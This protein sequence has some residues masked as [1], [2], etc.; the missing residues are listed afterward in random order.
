MDEDGDEEEDKV[1]VL[2]SDLGLIESHFCKLN[3][4]KMKNQIIN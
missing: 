4:K 3:Q 1:R 2:S